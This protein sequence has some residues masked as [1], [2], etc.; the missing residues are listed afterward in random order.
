MIRAVQ[1]FNC[2]Y[3]RRREIQLAENGHHPVRL[4]V[5]QMPAGCGVSGTAFTPGLRIEY[6]GHKK[7]LISLGRISRDTLASMHYDQYTADPRGG[8]VRVASN[9]DPRRR[10]FLKLSY[11][12]QTRLLGATLPGVHRYC[13]DWL[14]KLTARPRL[15]L[16]V[17]NT[18]A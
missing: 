13:A 6:V 11:F 8:L 4:S 10:G 2:A 5:E 9:T 16:V 14:E 1:E 17:D 12:A 18:R 15:R 3:G 7:D